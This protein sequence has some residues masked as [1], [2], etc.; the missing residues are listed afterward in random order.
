[1]S[2]IYHRWNYAQGLRKPFLCAIFVTILFTPW[3]QVIK[4]H[5]CFALV[6]LEVFTR[7]YGVNTITGSPPATYFDFKSY[8]VFMLTYSTK[9][10]QCNMNQAIKLKEFLTHLSS[11][12]TNKA[13][14][15]TVYQIT[16]YF[17]SAT[18]C[19]HRN[20]HP[21]A[22]AGGMTSISFS[23]ASCRASERWMSKCINS[24]KYKHTVIGTDRKLVLLV[25]KSKITSNSRNYWKDAAVEI[26]MQISSG[27]F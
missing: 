7:H 8:D 9:T 2:I 27:W 10:I 22:T 5:N 14:H 13:F 18:C 26:Q 21:A 3:Q 15:F 23:C 17:L 20:T 4:L 6:L 16:K 11:T 12:A 19:L 24:L 1:M 25:D